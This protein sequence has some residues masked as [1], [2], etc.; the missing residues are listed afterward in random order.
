MKGLLYLAAGLLGMWHMVDTGVWTVRQSIGIF[1]ICA[2]VGL[3]LGMIQEDK[4]Q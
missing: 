1:A 3:A 2:A 4:S